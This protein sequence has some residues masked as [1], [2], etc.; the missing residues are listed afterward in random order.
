MRD[1]SC[2]YVTN[3]VKVDFTESRWIHG[4][5]TEQGSC[6]LACIRNPRYD[7]SVP[8]GS[9]L[10]AEVKFVWVNLWISHNANGNPQGIRYAT[11]VFTDQ[12]PDEKD[13]K[14]GPNL[15]LKVVSYGGLE[16]GMGLETVVYRQRG[17]EP[18]SAEGHTVPNPAGEIRGTGWAEGSPRIR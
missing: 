3:S 10:A 6:R 18:P 17:D 8:I 5:C 9:H 13:R 4:T 1:L 11:E 14:E 15:V 7:Q 16:P 12:I 2:R